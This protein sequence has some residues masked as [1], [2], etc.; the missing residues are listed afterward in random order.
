MTTMRG[1]KK[2]K[3]WRVLNGLS[4][5]SAA[6]KAR[7]SQAAWNQWENGKKQPDVNNAVRIA[8][9]TEGAVAV[10]D[11]TDV[12]PP[13]AADSSP[14]PVARVRSHTSKRRAAS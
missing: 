6:A 4:Q 9:L 10:E 7:V 3:A 14:R 2:L 11:W 12:E 8:R 1:P 5:V 13:L